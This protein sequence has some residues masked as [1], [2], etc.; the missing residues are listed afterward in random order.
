MNGCQSDL[1][2]LLSVQLISRTSCA[3][4]LFRFDV[5]AVEWSHPAVMLRT[6]T[7][8]ALRQNRF[9]AGHRFVIS[10]WS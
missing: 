9:H 2:P 10:L 3:G 6:A 1:P 5:K 7:A 8:L 4:V